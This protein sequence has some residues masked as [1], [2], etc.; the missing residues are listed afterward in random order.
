LDFDS[1]LDYIVTAISDNLRQSPKGCANTIIL[2]ND[3]HHKG[4]YNL[5]HISVLTTNNRIIVLYIYIKL[6][7]HY[8]HPLPPRADT[9]SW[10]EDFLPSQTCRRTE[11]RQSSSTV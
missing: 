2:P 8:L 5:P 11:V 9:F 7:Y 3:Q 1:L 10:W 6:L 4:N